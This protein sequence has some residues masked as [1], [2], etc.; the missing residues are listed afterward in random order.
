[1]TERFD[2]RG[3]LRAG[4]AVLAG[5][6]AGCLGDGVEA[7]EA[8]NSGG[9]STPRVDPDQST[10]LDEHAHTQFRRDLRNQGYVDRTIPEEIE[11]DW[12]LP[13][14][15]AEHNAAKSTPV[16]TPDGD[17]V[18]AADTGKLRRV[19][20]GK[21]VLWT[22]EVEP[23]KRGMHGT[24]TIANGSVYVG[25]YDGAMYSFD[26]E[27][28]EREWRTDIGDAIGSSPKYYDGVCYIAVEYYDPSGSVAALD[29]A[30]GEIQ[31]NDGWPTSHPHSTIAIDREAGRL[32]VGSNDGNCYA[33]TFPGLEREWAYETR[34]DVKGPVGIV[35]GMAV[36]GSWDGWVYGVDLETG[37]KKWRFSASPDVMAGPAIAPDGTIYIGSHD[38]HLYSLNTDDGLANWRF[39]TD[40]YI[41]G[42]VTATR[43]HVLAGSWDTTM[44][45]V[46]AETGEE[47]WH[48]T[49]RGHATSAPL[50]T[51][52]AVYYAERRGSEDEP[53]QLYR[54]VEG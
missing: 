18:I 33:W 37:R 47:T 36:F 19:T 9:T 31:W 20:P 52:E 12:A 22:S 8:E 42:S 44:Y 46:D 25:A 21:E 53:G 4:T 54:L 23:T 3:F 7:P 15:R 2:R 1:M 50:V 41:I 5:G 29:A 48:H 38:R 26:L 16:R 45:A 30:T 17:I 34:G 10:S 32:V 28:G 40:G 39:G 14:N 11:V 13:I 35:D 6:L 49:G 51:D 27:T 24:P 43:D